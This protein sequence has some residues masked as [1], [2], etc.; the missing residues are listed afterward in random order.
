MRGRGVPGN[1]GRKHPRSSGRSERFKGRRCPMPSHRGKVRMAEAGAGSRSR[2]SLKIGK[3]GARDSLAGLF[4]ASCIARFLCF[5]CSLW[6]PR[7]WGST[8]PWANLALFLSLSPHADLSVSCHRPTLPAH[9]SV[10]LPTGGRSALR[11]DTFKSQS[12]RKH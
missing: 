4:S 1:L 2:A 3:A 9:V 7:I 6:S 11:Q 8:G 5:L 10:K 12:S